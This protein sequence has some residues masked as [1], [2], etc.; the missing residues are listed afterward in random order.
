MDKTCLDWAEPQVMIRCTS[1]KINQTIAVLTPTPTAVLPQGGGVMCPY[2]GTHQ[3]G[4]NIYY[5]LVALAS[6]GQAL[7]EDNN[8]VTNNSKLLHVHAISCAMYV[9][10][11]N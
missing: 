1:E 4:T 7:G 6:L 8:R 3:V 11:Q 9:T 2:Q 5:G 10:G